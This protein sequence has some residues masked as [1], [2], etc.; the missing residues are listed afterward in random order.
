MGVM[1]EAGIIREGTP[2]CVPSKEVSIPFVYD[3]YVLTIPM[4][5]A[6]KMHIL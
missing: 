1:V 3:V 2:I 6:F 4:V 5:C